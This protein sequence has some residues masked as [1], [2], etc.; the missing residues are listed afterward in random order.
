[1]AKISE[2]KPLLPSVLDRLL[3]AQRSIQQRDTARRRK[4]ETAGEYSA[5]PPPALARELL[6]RSIQDSELKAMLE[7]WKGTYPESFERLIRAYYELLNT[8]KIE[9][10]LE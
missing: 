2:S 9:N 7:R 5:K 1:M 3:D 6:E 10:G 8:K 4:S